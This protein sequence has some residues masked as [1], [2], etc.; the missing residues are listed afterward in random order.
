M[1][2]VSLVTLQLPSDC[3]IVFWTN[4]SEKQSITIFGATLPKEE[5]S[6]HNVRKEKN[7]LIWTFSHEIDHERKHR[8]TLTKKEAYT[9]NK[10]NSKHFCNFHS[11]K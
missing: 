1:K 9:R 5:M 8:V 10:K 4:E 11:Q 7:L 2:T 6:R 3:W